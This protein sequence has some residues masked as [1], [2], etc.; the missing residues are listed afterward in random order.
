VGVR[1]E[2]IKKRSQG[3]R[4]KNQ[5]VRA[6][7]ATNVWKGRQSKEVEAARVDPSPAGPLCQQRGRDEVVT[8]SRA[9]RGRFATAAIVDLL[10]RDGR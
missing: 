10:E 3:P 7:R 8:V 5:E 9:G 2:V 6:Q 4:S 1:K